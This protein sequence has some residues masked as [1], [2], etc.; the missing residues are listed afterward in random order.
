MKIG[1]KTLTIALLL[2]ALV[3]LNYLASR[4][5]LRVD[6][7]ADG[8]YTLS[9]GTKALLAKTEEPI[10]LDFYFSR[11]TAGMPVALVN[12]SERV[13]E[14]LRQYVRAS[15]GK[16]VLNVIDPQPD[17]PEEEKASAAGLEPQTLP[18]GGDQ[19]YFG[20]VATQ[21]DQ[22]K[23]ITSFNP[24]REQ[25]LEYDLSELV[26]SVQQLDK[27]KL[28]LI[29]SLPL[30]G[31][32]AAAMM[33]QAPQSG[34]YVATEWEDTYTI[35]PVQSGATELP[36]G[37]DALAIVHPENLDPKLQFAIDQF[38]LEGKP[39]FLAVDPASQYFK[40]Q[41]G[42]MAMFGGQQPNIS[43]DLPTLLGGWG[44]AYDPQKIVGDNENATEVQL[45][46]H[47][48]ARYPVWLSLVRDAFNPKALPTA[49]L[50]SMLFIE[51]GDVSLKPGSKLTFTPL[52]E[53]SEKAGEL[54]AMALQ[55]AQPDAVA[56]QITP[57]GRKVIAALVT[58]KFKTAFPDGPP[59]E[60]AKKDDAAATAA[61]KKEDAAKAAPSLK[62]SKGTS[63]LIV[64]ADTDWMLDDY[65]VEKMNFLGTAAARPINDN[66]SFAANALDFLAGSQDLISIRGKGSSLRQFTVVRRMEEQANEKYQ[67]KLTALESQLSEVES[68][69]S[70]LQGKKSEGNRLVAT[71]EVAKAI[72]DFQKQQATLRGERR[73]IRRALRVGIDALENRLLAI[74]LLATPLLVCAFGVWFYRS[75]KK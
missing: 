33:G 16:V 40:R 58:G 13:R 64:V 5:P 8:I 34:Q 65:S 31:N 44:I 25:F 12:Y 72:E 4:L 24:D 9:A 17:T 54:P 61:A 38:L 56:R 27:K 51:A 68:K 41:G 75:R 35:V 47:T 62:E 30:Q 19:F 26:Y 29:T 46:N 28:G 70:E 32:P 45:Q 63:T 52:V 53:T 2:A 7:T 23:A 18:N 60:E 21:A 48:L 15:R 59:K 10:T 71:P 1:R 43:S 39:V 57:S 55:M 14:M 20:L 69:L 66:L 3:L 37:L 49:Q 74:N 6:S 22:Q 50:N 73:E 11:S 36:A 67:Q 42:Q